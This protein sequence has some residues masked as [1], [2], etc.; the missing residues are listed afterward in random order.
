MPIID[1]YP[2]SSREFFP[3]Y[4]QRNSRLI[5]FRLRGSSDQQTLLEFDLRQGEMIFDRSKSGNKS[6]KV[7]RCQKEITVRLK[8]EIRKTNKNFFIFS[9]IPKV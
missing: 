4:F 1:T 6:A 8:Q 3:L 9:S 7:R 2:S 5:G